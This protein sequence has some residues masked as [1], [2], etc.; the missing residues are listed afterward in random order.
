MKEGSSCF[1][2]GVKALN[3]ATV[4]TMLRVK[5]AVMSKKGLIVRV[6]DSFL[7]AVFIRHYLGFWAA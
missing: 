2:K 5:N 1:N 3:M 6:I 4:R 7:M